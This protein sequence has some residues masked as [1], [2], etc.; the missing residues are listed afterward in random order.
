M[1]ILYIVCKG[2]IAALYLCK[3]LIQSLLQYLLLLWEKKPNAL[4][5]LYM[6]LGT[7]YIPLG[8]LH[9]QNPVISNSVVFN[10]LCCRGALAPNSSHI[11]TYTFSISFKILIYNSIPAIISLRQINSSALWLLADSPGPIF[12]AGV[13]ILI[14]SEVVGET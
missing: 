1:Y 11:T 3:N 13:S 4:K 7:K 9:I 10:S 5:H 8:Q 14:Q 6:R 2:E 12:M